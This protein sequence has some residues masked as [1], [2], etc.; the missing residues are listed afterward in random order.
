MLWLYWV[1]SFN[2]HKCNI[3]TLRI[4]EK[5]CSIVM[6]LCATQWRHVR[7]KKNAQEYIHSEDFYFN[8][9]NYCIFSKS[10]I[11]RTEI[12]K[13]WS[14]LTFKTG[15]VLNIFCYFM[16]LV[17]FLFLFFC[18]CLLRFTQ[19]KGQEPHIAEDYW[20]SLEICI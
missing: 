19:Y 10:D 9:N 3:N 16:R 8:V 2:A 11:T 4:C 17:I 18:F 13:F 7:T 12:G 14:T 6:R 15:Y 20:I 5:S 1:H